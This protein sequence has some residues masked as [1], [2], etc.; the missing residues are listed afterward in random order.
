[1]ETQRTITVRIREITREAVLRALERGQLNSGETA[2]GLG[3]SK[4]QVRPY[5]PHVVVA[6]CH[7]ECGTP[8]WLGA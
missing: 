7:F 1:M 2:E 5:S 8:V 4:R 6:M 3:L